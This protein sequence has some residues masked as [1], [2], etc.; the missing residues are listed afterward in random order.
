MTMSM[1]LALILA[2]SAAATAAHRTCM[3]MLAVDLRI[4]ATTLF[5]EIY[6]SF[7]SKQAVNFSKI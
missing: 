1:I 3:N 6:F 2:A 4:S 5:F 7:L